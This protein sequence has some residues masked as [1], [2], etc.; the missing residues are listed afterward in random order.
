[1]LELF[2]CMRLLPE[3]PEVV[4]TW[5]LEIQTPEGHSDPPFHTPK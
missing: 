3:V 5:C 4:E 2:Y 1:M